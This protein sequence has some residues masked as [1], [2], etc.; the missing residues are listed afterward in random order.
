M[1]ISK[2]DKENR[3]FL[4]LNVFDPNKNEFVDSNQALKL[5]LININQMTY[6]GFEP[7]ITF[8][9]AIERG[10][11]SIENNSSATNQTKLV[12]SKSS[13][14]LHRL[15]KQNQIIKLSNTNCLFVFPNQTGLIQLDEAIQKE[16]INVQKSIIKIPPSGKCITLENALNSNLI[17]VQN[18]LI[19]LTQNSNKSITLWDAGSYGY[20]KEVRIPKINFKYALEKGLIDPV[21]SMFHRSN[22]CDT[23]DSISV[24]EAIKEGLLELPDK[25]EFGK[26]VSIYNNKF[27]N[28]INCILLIKLY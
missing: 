11:M 4:I 8:D 26:K 15:F 13:L 25:N 21:T 19:F 2:S 23:S 5:G 12:K 22:N 1:N 14:T 10:F 27:K 17:D 28:Q 9:Q 16:L 6:H 3:K 7:F 18:G 20:L 24:Q